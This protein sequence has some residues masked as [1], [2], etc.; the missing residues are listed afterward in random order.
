MVSEWSTIAAAGAALGNPMGQAS[1]GTFY[2]LSPRCKLCSAGTCPGRLKHKRRIKYEPGIGPHLGPYHPS[3]SCSSTACSAHACG[4]ACSGCCR[5]LELVADAI[6][7]RNMAIWDLQVS[8]LVGG[9]SSTVVIF[10]ILAGLGQDS[11]YVQ[12]L[13][14]AVTLWH[15]DSVSIGSWGDALWSTCCCT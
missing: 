3:S 10:T 8:K 13:E 11:M 15:Q 9:S 6:L 12:Y 1:S 14:I 5:R 7:A 2:R 4:S